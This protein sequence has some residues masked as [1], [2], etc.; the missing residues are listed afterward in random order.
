MGGTWDCN[1]DIPDPDPEPELSSPLED[2][3]D[4]EELKED[5]K[6]MEKKLSQLKKELFQSIK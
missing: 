6:D 2:L 5:D 1:E 4:N 3:K